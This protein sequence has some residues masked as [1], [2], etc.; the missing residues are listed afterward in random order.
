[1]AQPGSKTL[2]RTPANATAGGMVST[3]V[4]AAT[5]A[6]HWPAG[7]MANAAARWPALLQAKLTVGHP[8]DIHEQ[9]ADRI[10]EEVVRLP[11]PA[12]AWSSI[13]PAPIRPL[14]LQRR[15]GAYEGEALM[16][17]TQAPHAETSNAAIDTVAAT[18]RQAGRPLDAATRSFF[19]PRFGADFS[20]VRIHTDSSAAASARNIH[21]LAYTVGRDVVFNTGQYAPHSNSGKRLLAHELTHVLQ[22]AGTDGEVLGRSHEK[23]RLRPIPQNRLARV[24]QRRLVMFGTLPDVNGMLGLLG[25]RAGLTLN[26]RVA[27]NQ[28]QIAAVLP[29]APPSPALRGQ[30][31]TIINHATQHAEVIVARGQPGVMVGAFPQPSDL[32][33]TRV[34]QIDLDD[35]LQIEAGAPGNGV[36]KAAHEIQENFVA[37]ATAPVPGTDLFAGAH[38]AAIAAESAVSAELVGP[39]RRV[40]TVSVNVGPGQDRMI[41]D[42]EN[43][44]LVYRTQLTASTQD[45]AITSARRRS[46]VVV[47]ARTIDNFP[48]GSILAPLGGATVPAAGAATVALAA[49]DVAATPTATVRVEG[50]ADDSEFSAGPTST[51]RATGVQAQLVAAGVAGGRIHAE[52]RGGVNFVAANDTNAHRSLNRRVVITVTRPGP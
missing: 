33:V 21:A 13:D 30:L 1:M 18:L 17:E 10:A 3:R 38:N 24:I 19:E 9:E 5:P 35:I 2:A 49:A 15:C 26:L 43:Y 28:V 42:F 32:T 20:A 45:V 25:P 44:Y 16:R 7:K 47:S 52:G 27:N 4:V 8:N 50:F 51:F 6:R 41:Q 48:T 29:A 34:Q 46:K 37:H 12:P 40:A 11:D 22:Q 14:S 39:G 31:T 23:R 36:A